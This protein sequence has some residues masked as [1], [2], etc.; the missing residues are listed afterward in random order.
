MGEGGGCGNGDHHKS[1]TL[2]DQE[3]ENRSKYV[4]PSAKVENPSNA[5][6]NASTEVGNPST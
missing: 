2:F 1:K 5:V 3:T 6:G 4:N